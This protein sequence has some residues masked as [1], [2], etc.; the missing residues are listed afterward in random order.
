MKQLSKT[1]NRILRRAAS[2]TVSVLLVF[3]LIVLTLFSGAAIFGVPQTVYAADGATDVVT[4]GAMSAEA[5][6]VSTAE[7][8]RL[9]SDK[10]DASFVLTNDIDMSGMD[11][12]PIPFSGTLDGNGHGI[13]NL[14][15]TR[16]GN[17]TAPTV[18]GNAKGYDSVLAGLFS[19]LDGADIHNLTIRGA[20]INVR[21]EQHCFAGVLAGWMKNTRVTD[22]VIEDSRVTL[23]AA[24]MPEADQD[25]KS[26]N[27]GVGGIAGFGAVDVDDS[28]INTVSGCQV[29]VTLI[30]DDQCDP[31][32]KVEE[33]LGGIVSAGCVEILD[34]RM[35]IQGYAA[36]RGYAHNGGLVGM[37]YDYAGADNKGT[38]TELRIFGCQVS[39]A[40]TFFEDN[41]DRRAYCDPYV[42]E[43]MT[44]PRYS[45]VHQ[46]FK[47]NEVF[48]YKTT[49]NPEKCAQPQ[50]ADTVIPGSCEAWGYTT[51]TCAECGNTWTDSFTPK[52]HE[53]GNWETVALPKGGI[54]GLME[55]RC[56]KCGE[57]VEQ[58]ILIAPQSFTLMPAETA[59]NYKDSVQIT[60][61]PV[62]QD[63]WVPNETWVSSDEVM[64]GKT[65]TSSDPSVAIV[66]SHGTVTA[67]GRGE[68][69]ITCSTPDGF[70]TGT[71]TIKVGYTFGQ[72]L[73][74]ILLFGWIWY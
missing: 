50:I 58:R 43:K 20:D 36:C 10:P 3:A 54:D 72:W 64:P 31:S 1:D 63:A 46:S 53:L 6:P 61:V 66:N 18:D 29:G 69:V 45:N 22:C 40:I 19:V 34:C 49:P 70:A 33:F 23:T 13:Y 52:V 48:D 12:T 7:D 9:L 39:G 16:F 56:V 37:L 62:P 17:D 24:C 11:W 4:I 67:T 41:R 51:H 68:A 74:K 42:G 25:R 57:I 30:F 5:I 38:G 26:C 60:A 32:L 15:V 28:G 65:W 2:L 14:K 8:L 47:N 71:C 27:S 44:W 55:Q 21:V 35:D 59:L 73:I